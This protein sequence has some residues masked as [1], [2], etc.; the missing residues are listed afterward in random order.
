MVKQVT[1]ALLMTEKRVKGSESTHQSIVHNLEQRLLKE[2]F[3]EMLVNTEYQHNGYCGEFD[4]CVVTQEHCRYYEVK[5]NYTPKN[6]QTAIKQFRRASLAYPKE[7]WQ[8]ILVT[9]QRI[10]LLHNIDVWSDSIKY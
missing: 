5:S 7:N 10:R 1:E 3:R 9:P 8:Y 6:L 2:G 4:V